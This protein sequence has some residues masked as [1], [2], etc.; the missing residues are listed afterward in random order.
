MKSLRDNINDYYSLNGNICGGNLHIVLDD[1]NLRDSDILFCKEECLKDNDLFGIALCD[2]LLK[3]PF[4]DRER[5][6]DKSLT[7][8][9]LKD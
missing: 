8:S 6:L 5:E 4:E 3:I 1:D 9:L 2:N 7:P